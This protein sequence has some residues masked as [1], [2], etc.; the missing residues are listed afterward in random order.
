METNNR[1]IETK[2]ELALLKLP[3]IDTSLTLASLAEANPKIQ[4][5]YNTEGFLVVERGL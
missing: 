3:E 1:E 4:I 2:D 5:E